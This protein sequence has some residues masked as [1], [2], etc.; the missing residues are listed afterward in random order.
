MDAAINRFIGQLRRKG[1]A[2]SPAE[3]MDAFEALAQ[4]ALVD[5][6]TVRTVLRTTLIKD[7]RH[8]AAFE[9][10]FD[11]FF[12]PP[13]ALTE[14]GEP[15]DIDADETALA[16][17]KVILD[18]EDDDIAFGG[19]PEPQQSDDIKIQPGRLAE[20]GENLLLKRA[21]SALDSVMDRATHQINMRRA[22][23]SVRPGTLSFADIIET[24]EADLAW[25]GMERLLADLRDLNVSEALID[26]LAEHEATIVRSLPDELRQLLEAELARLTAADHPQQPR[27]RSA[28]RLGFSETECQEMEEIVRRIGRRLRGARSYRR[29]ISRH[30]RIHVART[31]RNSMKYDGIPF[32]PVLTSN[33]KERPRI[34]VICD[35]SLSVRNTARFML[36]VVYSLQSLFDQVRSFVFVSD[37]ADASEYFEQMG[38]DE[39]IEAVFEGGLIDTD[40][41][42]NYG[43]ALEIFHHKYLSAVTNTSTVIVLGD[44][45]GNRHPPQAWVLHAIRRRAKQLIWLSPEPRGSWGLG[46]SD[47]PLYAPVCHRAEFVRDLAQLG[48][49]AETLFPGVGGDTHV[50]HHGAAGR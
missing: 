42:S 11:A 13:K 26:S 38:I 50:P 34:V 7:H 4:V 16:N 21:Q 8:N 41:N 28:G 47:M 29:V 24:L 20:F 39:A 49:F 40:A 1:V 17:E 44:G 31:L 33:R 6:E 15:L 30:G 35:V 46:S 32:K 48:Q 3:S 22:D 14:D 23:A 18:T 27:A 25:G 36:H 45:R 10:A 12:G 43:R 5:R 9:E 2:I 19:G 37:L